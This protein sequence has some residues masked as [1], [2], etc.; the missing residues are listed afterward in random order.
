MIQKDKELLLQDLCARIPYWVKVKVRHY[1]EYEDGTFKKYNEIKYFDA[2]ILDLL[3]S[4]DKSL[5]NIKPFL[6][7]ISSMTEEEKKEHNIF[8]EEYAPDDRWP[9]LTKNFVEE[10]IVSELIDWLNAHHFDYRNLIEKGLAIAVT[11]ENNPYKDFEPR[12]NF[13]CKEYFK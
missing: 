7:P 3:I 5:D 11:E 4:G 6:R 1:Y 10:N 8:F 9:Y 13:R 2:E 12:K